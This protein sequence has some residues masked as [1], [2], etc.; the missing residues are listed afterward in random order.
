LNR[1]EKITSFS[2]GE[3]YSGGSVWKRS[4]KGKDMGSSWKVIAAL[5]KKV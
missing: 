2:F 4:G 5:G 3:Y 1:D